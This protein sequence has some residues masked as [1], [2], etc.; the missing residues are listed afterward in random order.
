M[1]SS[2]VGLCLVY[3]MNVALTGAL[4][5]ITGNVSPIPRTWQE[6][7][8]KS[9][10]HLLGRE[11]ITEK[12]EDIRVRGITDNKRYWIGAYVN[13]TKWMHLRGCF[14]TN[15]Q[16]LFSK[17]G[18]HS[19][20]ECFKFCGK[21]SVGLSR[22][23]CVCLNRGF[24]PRGSEYCAA[25]PCP[26][27]TGEFCGSD[28]A[29]GTRTCLCW[30]TTINNHEDSDSK[31]GNCKTVTHPNGISLLET[32]NCSEKH[33]Y[34]CE[35]ER[36]GTPKL[37][38]RHEYK[39]WTE[40]GFSCHQN[41]QQFYDGRLVNRPIRPP[42]FWVGIFRKQIFNWATDTSPRAHDDCLSASVNKEGKLTPLVEKCD[43]PL[44]LLCQL[45]YSDLTPSNEETTP[46]TGNGG[47]EGY[48]VTQ[49]L[50][51]LVCG[52]V[53]TALASITSVVI[54]R[55]W[56]KNVDHQTSNNGQEVVDTASAHYEQISVGN[57]ESYIYDVSWRSANTHDYAT[58]LR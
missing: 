1:V 43:S 42:K 30:Y 54:F 29:L 45:N 17:L 51:G 46:P 9:D 55:Y 47:S 36:D 40:A 33:M 2:V 19:V 23:R 53:F 56:K 35:K 50:I 13:Y 7:M 49:W 4:V 32:T 41:G 8:R 58:I 20:S 48:E 21:H 27:N 18:S 12:V 38:E 3:M 16:G 37:V 15:I 25:T 5:L 39:N 44:P 31:I 11:F 52:I 24:P 10:C 28:G 6:G 26:L 22:D 57:S 34:L 14:Q